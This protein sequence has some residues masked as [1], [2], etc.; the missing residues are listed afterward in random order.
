MANRSR[1]PIEH[2]PTLAEQARQSTQKHL[3]RAAQAK[4]QTGDPLSKAEHRALSE[5]EREQTRRYG[6]RYVAAMPKADFLG[7]AGLSSKV[8]IEWRERHGFPYPEEKNA[9]VNL[10]EIIRHLWRE[11]T[12]KPNSADGIPDSDDVLL[13]GVPD[14][15]KI[16]LVKEKTRG[17][18]IA[19]ELRQIELE[20]AREQYVPLAPIMAAHNELA[21]RIRVT[22]E[23]LARR[24]DGRQKDEIER[25]FD[26]LIDDYQRAIANQFDDGDPDETSDSEAAGGE[27]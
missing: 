1:K 23:R 13:S 5:W 21:E 9:G 27:P 19:N 16:E 17:Q 3:L 14:A 6:S 11:V 2:E 20:R 22:R 18:R 12:G 4:L 26:D 15:V 25:A 8:C 24:F 7:G 10:F